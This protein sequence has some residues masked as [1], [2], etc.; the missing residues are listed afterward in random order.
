MQLQDVRQFGT[1][2]R[3]NGQGEIPAK[4]DIIKMAAFKIELVQNFGLIAQPQPN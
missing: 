3:L 2:G 1:E 4:D